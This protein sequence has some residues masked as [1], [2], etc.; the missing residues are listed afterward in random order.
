MFEVVRFYNV[1][2]PGEIVE[3]DW[4]AVIGKWRGQIKK[5][6]PITII[7]DG[8]QRRDFTHVDDIVEGLYKIGL[9]YHKQDDAWELG[10]GKNYSNK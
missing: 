3:G 10:T 5:N 8:K 2:G 1:Y 7:G 9:T 6:H 4:S